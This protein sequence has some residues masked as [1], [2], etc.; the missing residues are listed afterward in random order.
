M[1]KAKVIS[2]T[3]ELEQG[4]YKTYTIGFLVSLVLTLASYLL[5]IN[6]VLSGRWAMVFIVAALALTQAVVQLTLFLHLGSE[7]GPKFRL[8]VFSFMMSVVLILV[9]GSLWIMHN[10][11]YRMTTQQINNYMNSQDGGL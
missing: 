8:L 10:L 7:S 5:V 6:H 9:A 11:N 4:S 2:A 3:H 1:N